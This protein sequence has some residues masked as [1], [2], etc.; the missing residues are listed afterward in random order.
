MIP[1]VPFTQSS[2]FAQ[3]HCLVFNGTPGTWLRASSSSLHTRGHRAKMTAPAGAHYKTSVSISTAKKQEMFQMQSCAQYENSP[4]DSERIQLLLVR[5]MDQLITSVAM[6]CPWTECV[7]WLSSSTRQCSSFVDPHPPAG[8]Y[9]WMLQGIG[10]VAGPLSASLG[11]WVEG[12]SGNHGLYILVEGPAT[13]PWT[14]GCC[15]RA[16]HWSTE[17]SAM[18][19]GAESWPLVPRWCA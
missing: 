1:L 13:G 15:A 4:P 14:L 5:T 19:P 12:C 6:F 10:K 8:T 16:W 2:C 7:P 9:Q 11:P 3:I 18:G 17:R